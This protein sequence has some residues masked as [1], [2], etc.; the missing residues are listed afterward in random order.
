VREVIIALKMFGTREVSF[1]EIWPCVHSH[2]VT[3]FTDIAIDIGHP[4]KC[5]QSYRPRSLNF[6]VTCV[7]A[8]T[9]SP[10]KRKGS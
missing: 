6:T 8:S 3:K 7:S 4:M 5:L 1:N 9:G 10:L 2:R